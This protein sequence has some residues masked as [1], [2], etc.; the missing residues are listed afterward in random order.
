MLGLCSKRLPHNWKPPPGNFPTCGG[1]FDVP[2][3][4]KRLGEITSL[5]SAETFW[6]NRESAQK[7]ID[8]SGTIRGKLDPLTQAEKA[9]DDIKVMLE[10]GQAEPHAAQVSI[11]K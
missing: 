7:V 10:L 11:E 1:F 8:E 5:M 4:Q 6:N 3:L 9:L 2:Q